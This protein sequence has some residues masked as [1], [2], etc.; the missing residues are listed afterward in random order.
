MFSSSWLFCIHSWQCKRGQCCVQTDVHH[1]LIL[2][3]INISNYSFAAI[4][5]VLSQITIIIII[6]TIVI[7][8]IIRGRWVGE[9]ENGGSSVFCL[10]LRAFPGTEG[11]CVSV[12]QCTS[13]LAFK[14]SSFPPFSM[15]FP[16][17]CPNSEYRTENIIFLYISISVILH[18]EVFDMNMW[19]RNWFL[20]SNMDENILKPSHISCPAG[21]CIS[22]QICK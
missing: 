3:L 7:I 21:K 10:R 8:T 4:E 19:S 18:V 17:S 2:S 20:L 6:I 15:F 22:S 5:N 14:L 12:L 16:G 1:T 11:D 13:S 9:M